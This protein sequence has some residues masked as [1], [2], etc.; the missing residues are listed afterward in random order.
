MQTAGGAVGFAVVFAVVFGLHSLRR[1]AVRASVRQWE[2]DAY[3]EG[4][5]SY[6]VVWL[7]DDE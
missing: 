4:C 6:G 3:P 5:L 1:W 2:A 7:E